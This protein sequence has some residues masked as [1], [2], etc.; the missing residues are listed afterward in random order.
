MTH[1]YRQK[2]NKTITTVLCLILKKHSR[3]SNSLNN[4]F[5]PRLFHCICHQGHV[6]R[7][8]RLIKVVIKILFLSSVKFETIRIKWWNIRGGYIPTPWVRNNK[9]QKMKCERRLYPHPFLSCVYLLSAHVHPLTLEYWVKVMIRGEN[10]KKNIGRLDT[11]NS[12][13]PHVSRYKSER[14]YQNYI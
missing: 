1:K 6:T 12:V 10:P 7:K 13:T 4:I 8:I 14:K 5:N 9:N 11:S 3:F 2:Y